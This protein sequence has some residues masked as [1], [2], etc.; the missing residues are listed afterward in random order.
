MTTAPLRAVWQWSQQ[1]RW[2]SWMF[3][4]LFAIPL[5]Y[6]FGAGAVIGAFL[7]N[8]GKEAMEKAAKGQPI[9]WV[10]HGGDFVAPFLVSVVMSS[11]DLAGK[12]TG[13]A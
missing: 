12:L 5:C 8:E 10:D 11:F 7:F 4:A 1:A 3:H 2:R 6:A 9:D 13:A